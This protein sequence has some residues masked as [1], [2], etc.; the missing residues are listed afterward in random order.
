VSLKRQ[1]RRK[2]AK[3]LKREICA[4]LGNKQN[5]LGRHDTYLGK[6]E[7]KEETRQREYEYVNICE[8]MCW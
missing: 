1:T 2:C 6:Y 5:R 7:E 8:N 4:G 3:Y